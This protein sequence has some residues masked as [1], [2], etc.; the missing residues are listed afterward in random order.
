MTREEFLEKLLIAARSKNEPLIISEDTKVELINAREE[1]DHLV[2]IIKI[3]DKYDKTPVGSEREFIAKVVDSVLTGHCH[4]HIE[5]ISD[6]E[7]K[8]TIFDSI[9]LK[10]MIELNFKM[11]SSSGTSCFLEDYQIFQ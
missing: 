4:I 2:A 1:F 10:R 3:V 11:N 8:V 5:K 7:S 6:R 9:N